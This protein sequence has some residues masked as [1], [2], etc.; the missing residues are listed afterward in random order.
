MCRGW[1]G[2]PPR[3][4]HTHTHRVAGQEAVTQL[5]CPAVCP[6]ACFLTTTSF[7]SLK[8]GVR[9]LM[10]LE[11]APP[12]KRCLS[13]GSGELWRRS[14]LTCFPA[15]LTSP[16]PCFLPIRASGRSWESWG[17]PLPVPC[18]LLYLRLGP[19]VPTVLGSYAG[20]AS[21]FLAHT[22]KSLTPAGA[23]E[24][25]SSFK[26]SGISSRARERWG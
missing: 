23:A 9:A 14:D 16:E 5:C 10:P 12:G 3:T 22:S 26:V 8:G 15:W 17:F 2:P 7:S 20:Q 24:R 13:L 25:S 18:P 4:P 6:G 21:S 1:A 11:R 19:V